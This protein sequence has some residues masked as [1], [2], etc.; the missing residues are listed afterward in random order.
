LSMMT[1][2]LTAPA[3][4]TPASAAAAAGTSASARFAPAGAGA[5]AFT[6]GT[7]AAGASAAS[8]RLP[9]STSRRFSS[10]TRARRF[11]AGRRCPSTLLGAFARGCPR[12]LD[13]VFF[14]HQ[15]CLTLRFPAWHDGDLQLECAGIGTCKK[16]LGHNR[17]RSDAAVGWVTSSLSVASRQSPA[18]R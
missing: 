1:I 2:S 11:R 10:G 7:L 4:A 18:C 17:R 15:L 13:L 8:A 9:A 5:A 14:V 6:A 3:S 16:A 12:T